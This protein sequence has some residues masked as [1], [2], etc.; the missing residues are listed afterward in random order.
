[1][2]RIRRQI[3]DIQNFL[4]HTTSVTNRFR[5]AGLCQLLLKEKPFPLKT[6]FFDSLEKI[7][8]KRGRFFIAAEG[9]YVYNKLRTIQKRELPC[10]RKS[11]TT[12]KSWD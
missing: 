10:I 8:L 11:R 6:D 2:L 1:M 3:P 12:L 5:S 4:P 9:K 7:S